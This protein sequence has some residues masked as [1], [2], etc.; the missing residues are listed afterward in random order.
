ME[1]AVP[2]HFYTWTLTTLSPEVVIDGEIAY[3]ARLIDSLSFY[4]PLFFLF[5]FVILRWRAVR[6]R[7]S[8]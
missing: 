3:D 7:K 2:V 5:F 4:V 8:R 1:D 6:A